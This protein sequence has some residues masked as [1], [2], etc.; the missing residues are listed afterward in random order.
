MFP[1]VCLNCGH[2]VFV[3]AVIAGLVPEP[4]EER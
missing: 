3:S 2:T 4:G 1:V